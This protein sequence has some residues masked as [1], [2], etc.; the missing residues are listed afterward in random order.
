L[1]KENLRRGRN[2]HRYRLDWSDDAEAG[3]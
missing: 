1:A 3:N 2:L